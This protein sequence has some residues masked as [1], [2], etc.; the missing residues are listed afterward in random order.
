MADVHARRHAHIQWVWLS[1]CV[2]VSE[3]IYF[4]SNGDQVQVE[5]KNVCECVCD[6]EREKLEKHNFQRNFFFCKNYE[7]KTKVPEKEVKKKKLQIFIL[8][9]ENL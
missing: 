1:G 5:R 2:C 8:S 4:P 9:E 3:S 6:R 7:K